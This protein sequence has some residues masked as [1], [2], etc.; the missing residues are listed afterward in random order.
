MLGDDLVEHEFRSEIYF[1]E[2]RIKYPFEG[3]DILQ[4]VSLWTAFLCGMSFLQNRFRTTFLRRYPDDGSYKTWIVNRFGR[5]FFDIFFGPYSEKVW[6]I[7]TGELSQIVA[8]K[9]LAV[10][11]V[12]ELLHSLLFKVEQYHPENPRLQKNY[13]PRR[14]VGMI[15]DTFAREVELFGG[16]IVLGAH[17]ERLRFEDSRISEVNFVKDGV[18]QSIRMGAN[19]HV[20]ST[21]PL[22]EM[23]LMLDG[24]V[25]R[26]V[27]ESA[28]K[29]DFTA[30]VFLYMNVKRE[31]IFGLPL[32][33]FSERDF[34][35]NRVYDVGIFSRDMCQ[36]GKN[37][38]CF[39]LTCTNGDAV[40]NED[41]AS[42][43]QRSIEPLERHGLLR[44]E[45]VEGY[46]TRRLA[47]AYPRFRIGYENHLRTIF[48]F[49]DNTGGL[50]SFGREGLFAYANIDDCIWMSTEVTKHLPYLDRMPL[51]MSE[52]LPDYIS[53]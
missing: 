10:R 27:R 6:G 5:R 11:G 46:H 9:R 51:R 33:Y 15:P 3:A 20:F 13:Y 24:P 1:Q 53:A 30:E 42:L 45:D 17:V 28:G 36:D 44:R 21:L 26:T 29:L 49:V 43:Y 14:G 19:D 50:T 39:E 16:E 4:A 52:L 12:I 38:L 18:R 31:T 35:F 41:D 47:H 40:W 25:P 7:P 23:I 2:K 22:N 8:E 32:F 37:A 48:E 34:P